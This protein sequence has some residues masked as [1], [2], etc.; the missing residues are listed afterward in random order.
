MN[1]VRFA[2]ILLCSLARADDFPKVYN[3]EPLSDE[4][5]PS[6]QEAAEGFQVP[7]G[8]NVSVFAS[9]PEVRNPIAMSW[10]E[11]GRMWVAENYTFA[12]RKKRFDF[13][14]SDRVVI[15]EDFDD[16]GKSDKRTVFI[17]DVKNLTG[18][19]KDQHGL[20]L[21]CPCLLYTSPSPRDRTR[22]RM[23]SSA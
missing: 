5:L 15:F 16:D 19:E 14:L 20:W 3:S 18:L 11:E 13:T 17:D 23:P 10:D 21:M 4:T 6:A 12:E 7:Y 9:E 2:G 8:F 1:F 22:S